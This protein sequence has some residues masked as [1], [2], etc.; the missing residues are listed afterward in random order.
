MTT[1]RAETRAVMR[2]VNE[3]DATVLLSMRQHFPRG[4][5]ER[6]T[7]RLDIEDR[8]RDRH[9]I[10]TNGG[11]D[12]E[13]CPGIEHDPMPPNWSPA[14]LTPQGRCAVLFPAPCAK[15]LQRGQPG[16]GPGE[17]L[18]AGQLRSAGLKPARITWIPMV[19]CVPVDAQGRE[20]P[21]D[22]AELAANW[23]R[24]IEYLDAAD[25]R[26]VLLH[27][28][29]AIRAWRPDVKASEQSGVQGVMR[30]RWF[31][32]P[33]PHG[34]AALRPNG[35]PMTEW[36][37]SVAEFARRVTEDVGLAGLGTQCIK[38]RAGL[39]AY[40]P[41]GLALCGKHFKT[42]RDRTEKVTMN[43]AKERAAATQR[44][45]L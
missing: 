32:T 38:C 14:N 40:D 11:F 36:S 25:V 17:R 24:V 37:R 3:F 44:G 29:Q 10:D 22:A 16:W 12:C 31:V 6:A 20:R 39:Y 19:N 42:H 43:R 21:P 26:Y 35:I 27:G 5:R 28:T 33:I 4:A 23:M 13:L 30:H 18:L 34:T 7:M 9:A 41:D 1:R 2:L 45:M 15:D 8:A